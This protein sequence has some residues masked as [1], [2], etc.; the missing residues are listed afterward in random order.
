MKDYTW[1]ETENLMNVTVPLKGVH[2]KKLDV[3]L[4]NE[5]LKV[6]YAPFFFECF[7]RN[8][9]DHKKSV[10][11]VCDGEVIF[12]LHKETAG[13]WNKLESEITED[14]NAMKQKRNEAIEKAQKEEE[15]CKNQQEE[16]NRKDKRFALKKIMSIED[17]EKKRIQD[18]K[19]L[20]KQHAMEELQKWKEK[21]QEVQKSI[22]EQIIK[23]NSF[24]KEKL[25]KQKKKQEIFPVIPLRPSGNIDVNF[26][27]RVFPTPFRESQT[28][29][30][31][32]WL[33]KQA[34]ARRMS[35]VFDENLSEEERNPDLLQTKGNN[36]FHIGN[37]PA[38]INVY[39]HAIKLSNQIPAL[40]SNRAACHLKVRNFMKCIQDCSK[41]LDLMHP[42]VPQNA[43]SRCR[44]L[45][46]RGTAFCELE[47]YI[48]GLQDY[49]AALKLDPNNK[50]LQDDAENIRNIIQGTR[51][52]K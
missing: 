8:P 38:A 41:A 12:Q 6:N 3:F 30:E 20:E 39:T 34:E 26:T 2:R 32:K 44:A 4:T 25:T 51:I 23:D 42:C 29:E 22:K 49:D 47:L 31:E 9:I 11:H 1:Q 28:E 21:Q 7:L 50:Q 16:T 46:R 27:P 14:K 43:T 36:F 48:E 33:K 10:A 40:Y 17:E 19:D 45:V 24:K 15:E 37:Y 52:K 35:E 18:I 13:L 5:Y